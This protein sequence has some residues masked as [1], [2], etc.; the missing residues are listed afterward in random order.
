M[1]RILA[2]TLVLPVAAAACA[3]PPPASVV[4]AYVGS[5]ACTECHAA[6]AE[7]VAGR[8]HQRAM[9]PARAGTV[10]GHFD[11]SRLS[12]FGAPTEF[13][14]QGGAPFVRTTGEA[15]ILA[16]HE[17]TYVLGVHPLEQY[18]VPGRGG[19]YQVL[20]FAWD[21]RPD[22]EGGERWFHLYP[23]EPVLPADELHWTGPLQTWNYM[24][25]ECHVTG[26]ARN[27][28]LA[29][30]S[31]RTAWQEL[32]VQCEACHGPGSAH[33]AWARL[34]QGDSATA[35]AQDAAGTTGFGV[36]LGTG[37]GEWVR[38]TGEAFARRTEPL[39]WNA[40]TEACGA[41]HARRESLV[42]A[43]LPGRPLLATHRPELLVEGLYN[44]DGQML[45]EV[46]EYG[47]F[48]QSRMYRAGVT[49]SDCHHPSTQEVPPGNLVCAKC[50]QPDVYDSRA[51]HFHDPDS[52]GGSCIAC[53]MLPRT[54][55]VI[56]VRHDHSIRV[57]RPDLSLRIGS[58]NTCTACH[59]DGSDE[60]A[61]RAARRWYGPPERARHYGDVL[62]AGRRRLPAADTALLRLAGDTAEPGIVRATAVSLLDR[63]PTARAANGIAQAARDPEPLVRLAAALAAGA[64]A[65]A[66]RLAALSHLLTDSLLALRVEAAR[67]LGEVQ[68]HT[69]APVQ[70]T[71][72]N[73]FVAA[74]R[75]N[76][77]QPESHIR[78]G[79]LHLQQGEVAEAERAYRDA[80][81]VRP[82]YLGGYLN[83]ADLYRAQGRDPEG[84]QVL[85]EGLRNVHR[86]AA[87]HHSLGLLLVRRRA[88]DDAVTELGRAAE[89]E[90]DVPRF[91]Q[92][93]GIA[94]HSV[95]RT[96]EARRVLEDARRRAPNDAGINEALAAIAGQ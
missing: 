81:R 77:D 23:D 4:A 13:F 49:C 59:T 1:R 88:L 37:A 80:I 40:Q 38:D 14:L 61:A 47:S 87:L 3:P 64:L 82:R 31:Y 27:Y 39:G 83:L 54:Y 51:H 91:A 58:P 92:V 95:G 50:H 11:G 96:A 57:P 70:R 15:G 69:L 67:A 42:A 55:M 73:E 8:A 9:R 86:P 94:L 19:R 30:D 75:V 56:D 68:E 72:F 7:L 28:D 76:A 60:W 20:P 33:V 66:A 25:A 84:E 29:S 35:R 78:L 22:G 65:P 79:L 71:A 85:R 41:C 53:H 5:A 24:C 32:G 12:H 36:D 63:Y 26:A 16:E 44:A 74:Q 45:D 17:V 46:Y 2:L 52:S 90:P 21:A 62:D 93:Y 48:L 34:L 18:L 10:S 89:L 43:W 6:A